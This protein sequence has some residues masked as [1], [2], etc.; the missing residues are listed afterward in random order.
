MAQLL[1]CDSGCYRNY[2]ELP[3]NAN[4]RDG[5]PWD[6]SSFLVQ[7]ESLRRSSP[8][9][10]IVTL[11]LLVAKDDV[12]GGRTT[13]IV[14]ELNT[15]QR[16]STLGVFVNLNRVLILLRSIE[17][18][19]AV[20]GNEKRGDAIFKLDGSHNVSTIGLIDGAVHRADRHVLAVKL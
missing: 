1:E 8:R 16:R 5:V 3:D 9:K 18:Q 19:D 20:A 4:S 6:H 17:R 14:L 15:L 10:P 12:A 11:G 13:G 2:N 7:I